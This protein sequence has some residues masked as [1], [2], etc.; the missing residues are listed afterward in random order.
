MNK[1]WFYEILGYWL[2]EVNGELGNFAKSLL[3]EKT[4]FW[5]LEILVPVHSEWY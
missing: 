5:L 4:I 2:N 1:M 3:T